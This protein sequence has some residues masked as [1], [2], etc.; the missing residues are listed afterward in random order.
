MPAAVSF[1]YHHHHLILLFDMVE[2]Y[3]VLYNFHA[4]EEGELSVDAGDIV[5]KV[6]SQS[7]KKQEDDNDGPYNDD[8]NGAIF[9]SY[10]C[11]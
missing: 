11:I 3:L 7:K 6:H 8:D 5:C 9:P 1:F 4:E 2:H 10:Y